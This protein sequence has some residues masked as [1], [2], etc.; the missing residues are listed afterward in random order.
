MPK[1]TSINK[2]TVSEVMRE[3]GARGGK[4][5]GKRRL[6]TMTPEERKKSASKAAKARWSKKAK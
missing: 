6:Q 5:G 4:I 3:M 1:R 2:S